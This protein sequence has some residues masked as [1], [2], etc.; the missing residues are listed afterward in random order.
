MENRKGVLV[1]FSLI[2]LL[3]L[4]CI[5]QP[6]SSEVNKIPAVL[7]KNTEYNYAFFY[8]QNWNV[9]K[10]IDPRKWAI[11]D[12]SNNAIVMIVKQNIS[13]DLVQLGQVEAKND[14]LPNVIS[15]NEVANIV[16]I[17]KSDHAQFFTYAL[18]FDQKG[19]DTIVS[20]T[21]CNGNE[22]EFILVANNDD[23]EQKKFTYL[24]LVNSFNCNP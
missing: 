4:S 11:T 19:L 18:R 20:G 24:Q 2:C 8:P 9:T 12:K 15:D 23:F 22:I 14:Y 21:V 3:L 17:M 1:I 10:D 16:K 7:Y 6:G 5:K 13:F